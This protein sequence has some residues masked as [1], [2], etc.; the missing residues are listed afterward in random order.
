MKKASRKNRT[1]VCALFSSSLLLTMAGM[2]QAEEFTLDQVVVTA[3]KTPVKKSEVNANIT[4]ITKEKIEQQHYTD[5]SQALR[6]VPGVTVYNFGSPGYDQTNGLRIN[7]SDKIVVLIDGIRANQA[8]L[9]FPA[10]MYNNLDNVERIEVLKGSASALYGADAQGGVINIITRKVDK[11]RTAVSVSGGSFGKE[12]Y[13][14]TQE[15]VE[16]DMSYRLYAAKDLL[17]TMEDGNGRKMPQSLDNKTI[18]FQITQKLK[19]NSDITFSYD[20]EMSDYMYLSQY[21]YDWSGWP[22]ARTPDYLAFGSLETNKTKLIYNTQ[23]NDKTRNQFSV[24]H[25]VY[26]SVDGSYGPKKVKTL[27]IQDQFTKQ[28]NEQHT[29]TAGIDYSK[30]K[31]V[32]G[33]NSSWN[34]Q[35][36]DGMSITNK[37]VYIQDEWKM[38]RQWNLTTGIRYDDNSGYKSEITPHVTL[39]FKQNDKTNYYVSYGEFF[40]TPTTYQLWDGKHG[41]SSLK[42]ESGDNAEFGVTHQISDTATVSAHIFKR[43][44]DQKISYNNITKHYYN[45]DAN[46]ESTGWDVQFNKKFSDKFRGSLGYTHTHVDAVGSTSENVN[47]YIP[48]QAWNVGV[49]YT[50]GRLDIGLMGR[51]IIDKVGNTGYSAV[52]P[53]STYWVW[54]IG[55]NY[56]VDKNAKAFLK[57]NNI[58]DKFYA[59][60]SNVAWG[61]A[62]EWWA[63]PGRN[64]VAG[65]NYSF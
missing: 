10:S 51:G 3:T 25:S 45:L 4:V 24:M 60:Q 65:I 30:D 6:D 49:D 20:R 42:P 12:R 13:S 55:I 52:F 26:D 48:K 56:Q 41:N 38:D 44:V 34:T 64:V 62:G 32:K 15:G 35:T 61:A 36:P 46:E 29:L 54:D 53:S 1:L 58:F 23:I 16:G 19:A 22:P 28:L 59:E 63:M 47:G 43:T 11:D 8:D 33:Y 39:G 21:N 18:G 27:V 5:L 31:L 50:Q 40:N 7:G 17:G 14:I 2:A 57:V 9:K 37:A